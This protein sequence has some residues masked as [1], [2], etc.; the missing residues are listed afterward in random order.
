[1]S[2][3]TF[4]GVVDTPPMPKTVKDYTQK[5]V[6]SRLREMYLATA[7]PI[8]GPGKI[9]YGHIEAMVCWPK[10]VH[11]TMHDEFRSICKVIGAKHVKWDGLDPNI[12]RFA[13]P[14]PSERA[15]YNIGGGE[16]SE[17]DYDNFSHK[18]TY[19]K[20]FG[21]SDTESISSNSGD[22]KGS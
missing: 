16:M 11:E 20:L 19:S 18:D 14:Y 17:D 4:A 12:A 15:V 3:T 5:W 21:K 2:G 13:I 10:N 9:E 6:L 8:D 22:Q 7:S 1:M